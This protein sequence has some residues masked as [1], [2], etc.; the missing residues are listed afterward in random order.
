M[1]CLECN[2]E[3]V[4]VH[5]LTKRCNECA[6]KRRALKFKKY[7]KKQRENFSEE[8]KQVLRDKKNQ[9]RNLRR[10]LGLCP[11]CGRERVSELISCL[12]CV[13]QN[14][15]AAS[16]YNRKVG[17]KPQGQSQAEEYIQQFLNPELI[18]HKRFRRLIKNPETNRWLEL[19][20]WLPE[21]RLAVEI[22]GPMHRP[23]SGYGEQRFLYQQKQDQ[24]KNLLCEQS[25]VELLRIPT[26]ADYW[27]D[28]E[29]LQIILSQAIQK[30]K[31]RME[32]ATHNS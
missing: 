4:N 2:I 32:G 10:N 26:N 23:D 31:S 15:K 20:L 1:N 16:K 8:Y 19:D 25:N 28:K 21:V 27:K 12:S 6:N 7:K 18:C 24:L 29:Q 5:H 13:L 3:L 9:K 14:K 30:A 11:E 22:D 17:H